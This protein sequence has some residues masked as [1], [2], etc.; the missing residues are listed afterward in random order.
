MKIIYLFILLLTACQVKT[1]HK[2]E[3][4]IKQGKLNLFLVSDVLSSNQIKLSDGKIV[5]YMGLRSSE[6]IKQT[7]KDAN[8]WLLRIGK[9]FLEFP[10]I[11]SN[12][13]DIYFAYAYVPTP[14]GL[15]FINREL[16]EFGYCELDPEFSDPKY[17]QYKEEFFLLQ[18]EAQIKK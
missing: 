1:I 2:W 4:P 17:P 7:C 6:K 18:K 8:Q 15:C 12:K 5:Q 14:K 16:L 3:D 9:I 10:D 13:K 11:Q